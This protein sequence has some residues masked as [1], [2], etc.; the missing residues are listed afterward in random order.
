MEVAMHEDLRLQQRLVD[1]EF[2]GDRQQPAL[3]G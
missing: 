2:E 3:L 1:Q